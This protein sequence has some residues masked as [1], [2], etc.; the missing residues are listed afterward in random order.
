MNPHLIPQP[1]VEAHLIVFNLSHCRLGGSENALTEPRKL[2]PVSR[3]WNSQGSLVTT[4]AG[5]STVVPKVPI[6]SFR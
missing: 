6:L 4:V 2:T 3:S 5:S 1:R